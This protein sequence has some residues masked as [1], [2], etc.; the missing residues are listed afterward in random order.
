MVNKIKFNRIKK[1]HP[2]LKIWQM[3]RRQEQARNNLYR[4]LKSFAKKW[5]IHPYVK[6]YKEQ[7]EALD[8]EMNKWEW[9]VNKTEVLKERIKNVVLE[10]LKK[11][12]IKVEDCVWYKYKWKKISIE[13]P[14]IWDDF[15]WFKC[16]YFFSE[17]PISYD[18]LS[19][20]YENGNSGT[21]S[22]MYDLMCTSKDLRKLTEGLYKYLYL[23]WVCLNRYEIAEFFDNFFTKDLWLKGRLYRILDNT[24]H[25]FWGYEYWDIRDRK[26]RLYSREGPHD[27]SE[28]CHERGK[29]KRCFVLKRWF[30]STDK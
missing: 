18:R 5:E 21:Y 9:M 28:W 22:E 27:F 26:L 7:L 3:S 4:S 2:E 6:T 19:Y 8:S 13:L 11:N 29:E 30:K 23:N 16:E 24:N 14:Q 25:L 17:D 20:M 1:E 10:D 15:K 12:C